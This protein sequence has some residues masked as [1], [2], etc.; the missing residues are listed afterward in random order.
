MTRLRKSSALLTSTVLALGSTAPT[1]LPKRNAEQVAEALCLHSH[2]E[3]LCVIVFST[4]AK[5]IEI[6][7]ANIVSHYAESDEMYIGNPF[8]LDMLALV[9]LGAMP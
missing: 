2:V 9:S 1:H 8:S 5:S 4:G 7:Q 3:R 6:V